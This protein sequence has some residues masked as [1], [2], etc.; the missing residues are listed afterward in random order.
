MKTKYE[1]SFNYT[2]ETTGRGEIRLT[3]VSVGQQDF[4]DYDL[5][6]IEFK[7]TSGGSRGVYSYLQ[8]RLIKQGKEKC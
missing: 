5:L 2:N 1:V 7:Q 4:H 6:S 8:F 3:L